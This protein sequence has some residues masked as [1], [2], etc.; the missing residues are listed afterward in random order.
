MNRSVL[1]RIAATLFVTPV[2]VAGVL[3]F[4]P[5]LSSAGDTALPLR[6]RISTV[7]FHGDQARDSLPKAKTG[8]AL[9]VSS[10]AAVLSGQV[11]AR[12]QPTHFKF[13]YG[14]TRP[15]SHITQTGEEDV[16]GHRTE[17]VSEAAT[18][19]KPGTT[20]HFR[21]IAFNDFGFVAGTDRTF[22]T[23]GPHS[24]SGN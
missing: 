9:L 22:T 6:A 18:H 14:R 15:Y 1:T 4:C 5:G 21:I 16:V 10:T 13:Q 3:T 17:I 20:Y 24:H 2:V 7:A 11:N 12:N 8:K 23:I 19:L